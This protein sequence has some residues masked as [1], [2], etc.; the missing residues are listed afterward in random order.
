MGLVTAGVFPVFE[1]SFKI[2]I[3]GLESTTEDMVTVANCESLTVSI[4]NG[5]QNW[6]AMEKQGWQDSLQTTKALTLA[7]TGKRTVGDAGND[8]VASKAFA[9]GRDVETKYEWTMP[10]GTVLAGNCLL[11]VS[12]VGGGNTG[13]VGA[14]EFECLNNGIPTITPGA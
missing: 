11:N 7:V 14:L 13:D 6:N 3:K 12:N 2:G 9:T 5:V 10:D 8:Y 4:D 1:N